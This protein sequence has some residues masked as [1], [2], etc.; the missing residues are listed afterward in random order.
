MSVKLVHSLKFKF[1]WASLPLS[2]ASNPT[3]QPCEKLR[4]GKGLEWVMWPALGYFWWKQSVF[5]MVLLRQLE[6]CAAHLLIVLLDE[7]PVLPY[8]PCSVLWKTNLGENALAL[9]L[10]GQ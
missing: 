9:H 6:V 10:L 2:L 3:T 1:N 7:L 5:Y 4:V 8:S